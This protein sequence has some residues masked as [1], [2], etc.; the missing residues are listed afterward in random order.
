[1]ISKLRF[2]WRDDYAYAFATKRAA[3]M[4]VAWLNRSPGPRLIASE[5]F[6]V[7]E[8]D[9]VV[10]EEHDRTRFHYQVKCQYTDFDTKPVRRS[11]AASDA[12]SIQRPRS[13]VMNDRSRGLNSTVDTHI[14]KAPIRHARLPRL[15][16]GDEKKP[17][18]APTSA[19][20]SPLDQ[21][22]RELARASH[23]ARWD[24]TIDSYRRQFVLV[25]PAESLQV[26]KGFTLA[27]L[28]EFIERCRKSG[29]IADR[30]DQPGDEP[31]LNTRTW[32]MS[33]CGFVDDEHILRALSHVRILTVG[34]TADLET[35]TDKLLQPLF[36]K[37]AEVRR[38]IFH[39][40]NE[41]ADTAQGTT[42]RLLLPRVSDYLYE[43]YRR[44]ILYH[45]DPLEPR[46]STAGT[47]ELHHQPSVTSADAVQ[48]LWIPGNNAPRELCIAAQPHPKCSLRRSLVRL[49]AHAQIAQAEVCIT[50]HIQWKNQAA[51]WVGGTLGTAGNDEIGSNWRSYGDMPLPV[52]SCSLPEGDDASENAAQALTDQMDMRAWNE[53]VRV[54]NDRV[55][56]YGAK[57]LTISMA[58]VWKRWRSEVK[59][60]REQAE[61]MRSLLQAHAERGNSALA[62]I[63]VGPRTVE[64]MASG[65]LLNLALVAIL[66]PEHGTWNKMVGKDTHTIA[67]CRCSNLDDPSSKAKEIF[68]QAQAL[69]CQEAAPIVLLPGTDASPEELLPESLGDDDASLMR[70]GYRK[71]PEAVF[72]SYVCRY[73]ESD[74][75]KLRCV[76]EKRLKRYSD[77][78]QALLEASVKEAVHD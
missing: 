19:D 53:L 38:A 37:P 1:M 22:F 36:N 40:L 23:D 46:W 48:F 31:T 77:A 21:M 4:L 50:D 43:T 56:E 15:T 76:V 58:A 51:N 27:H 9:D 72:T 60:V 20:L 55:D 68:R 57:E 74:V 64:L 17:H 2:K 18:A 30:L 49:A 66:D 34:A 10:V 70:V 54:V 61:L 69:L 73:A 52:D 26:K 78:R 35:E 41:N 39:F 16:G 25:V 59:D 44:W 5:H 71:Y 32:L 24:G 14:L 67:L 13:S 3:E 11:S 45:H 75:G 47:I 63:R 6:A 29:Q 8:W 28:R 12:S 42:P 33:W 65:V 7:K 62:A